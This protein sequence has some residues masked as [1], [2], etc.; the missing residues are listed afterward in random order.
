MMTGIN[1]REARQ[2]HELL[3]RYMKGDLRARI[4]AI[5][6]YHMATGAGWREAAEAI[7]DRLPWNYRAGIDR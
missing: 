7:D 4:D 3:D 5:R 1:A 2:I 6:S